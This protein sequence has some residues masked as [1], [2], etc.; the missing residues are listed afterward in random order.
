[1]TA[2][3]TAAQ[4]TEMMKT[5][6]LS[7]LFQVTQVVFQTILKQIKNQ[8]CTINLIAIAIY[9]KKKKKSVLCV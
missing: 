3:Q 4:S 8:G 6:N 5:I 9:L 1:M 7:L 2:L